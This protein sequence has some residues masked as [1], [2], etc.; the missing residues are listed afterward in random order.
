MACIRVTFDT[1]I[2]NLVACPN[3]A[4]SPE[5]VEIGHKL[6]KAI[7]DGRIRSFV[8]EASVFV[9]CLG[10]PEKLT[11]L[12]VAG[13]RDSRPAPD[14]RRVAVFDELTRL[15]AR[16]LYAPLIGAERFISMPWADNEVFPF[17]ERSKRFGEFCG[18]YP[19]HK[20]LI[21]LGNQLL[22][23]QPPVPPRKVTVTPT[24]SHH[25]I[26]PP[27]A[28]A[29]KRAWDHGD[30]TERKRLR[31]EIEPLICEWCDV[32]IVGSHYAY[33]NN[34]LCIFDRGSNAGASSIMHPASR[35]KLAARGI[36][37]SSP[38]DLV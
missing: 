19:M 6:R 38:A 36:I 1:N 26:P 4:S 10:F 32:L 29:L 18:P 13:T 27:W 11:Y 15:G 21:A 31:K 24:G 22:V 12:S 17:H 34:V 2:C 5:N 28:I 3:E 33:E 7:E 25:E 30:T 37:I 16:L 9:E 14:A 8:S 23:G 35:A 20:P